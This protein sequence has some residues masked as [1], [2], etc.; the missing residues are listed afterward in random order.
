MCF[1]ITLHIIDL[2][3]YHACFII[4]GTQIHPLC[5]PTYAVIAP[6]RVARGAFVTHRHTYAS[7]RCRT[8]QY[9]KNFIPPSAHP[10]N[11][12]TDRWSVRS[13]VW[14][15]RV[16]RAGQ[17]FLLSEDVRSLFFFY[18]FPI[19]FFLS[20]GWYYQLI[21]DTIETKPV[22]CCTEIKLHWNAALKSTPKALWRCWEI[23]KHSVHSRPLLKAN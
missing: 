2:W 8:S 1:S 19:F 11:D 14:D 3:Q 5:C 16:L 20:T 9:R 6:V 18:W 21:D 7:L 10:W 12:L 17:C 13:M 23:V 15:W 4:R 22:E